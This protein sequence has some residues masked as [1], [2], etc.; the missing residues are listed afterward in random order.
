MAWKARTWD[1]NWPPYEDNREWKKNKHD[2]IA[3]R[4]AKGEED[5]VIVRKERDEKDDR[6]F[7]QDYKIVTNQEAKDEYDPPD[8]PGDAEKIDKLLGELDA[9]VSI[10]GTV[11][12]PKVIIS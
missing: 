9:H 5:H 8:K 2:L 7:L 1:D 4:M 10:Q 6:P 12:G 3:E 11:S